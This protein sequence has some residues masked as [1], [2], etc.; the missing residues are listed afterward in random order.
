M[1]WRCVFSALR[2]RRRRLLLALSGLSVAAMLVTAL[3]SVYSDIDRKL[4]AEFRGYG[5]NLVIARP[6]G[7]PLRAVAV[8]ERLGAKAE[9]VIYTVGRIGREPVVLAGFDFTRAAPFTSYWR[10]AGA[11]FVSRGECLVGSLAASHFHLRIGGSAGPWVVRGIVTTGGPED[12][13]IILP[14]EAAAGA[15]GLSDSASLVQVRAD[16]RRL[17]Q[18]RAALAAALPDT[19]VRIVRAIAET[20]AGVVMKVRTALFLLTGLI[21]AVTTLCVS[22]NFSAL[23]LERS[24]EIGMLK[25]IG[26][27]ERKIAALLISESLIL[28]LA[29]TAPGYAVGLGVAYW[30]GRQ[31]FPGSSVGVR[32]AVLGP[33]TAV[34]LGIAA[35]ATLLPASR[36]WRIHPAA[37]L[38]GE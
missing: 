31:V 9:P 35:I 16:G 36:I 27:A 24:R 11:K 1:F 19:D 30:I 3:F 5:A 26:A 37:I 10:I 20:E 13:Q 15:A 12:N 28:A 8:A 29:S 25:A 14:F 7:V 33:A 17:A 22:S 32:F 2:Y 34:T 23:V 6:G 21:L 18:T 38:R 4:H